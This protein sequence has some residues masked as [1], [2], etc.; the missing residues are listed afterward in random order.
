MLPEFN[1]EWDPQNC[2]ILG[3]T[4]TTDLNNITDRNINKHMNKIRTEIESWGKRNLTPFGKVALIKAIFISRIVHILTALQNPSEETVLTLQLIFNNFL[5]NEKQNKIRKDV[6]YRPLDKGGLGMLDV[7][8]NFQA[9]KTSWIRRIKNSKSLSKEFLHKIG[10][11]YK[12]GPSIKTITNNC[13]Y[14]WKDVFDSYFYLSSKVHP[15][16][17]HEFETLVSY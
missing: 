11:I 5:W 4:F 7:K 2:S 12:K 13:K 14:F 3:V 10:T 1:L 15:T 6:A 9:L 17:L 16:T 8:K